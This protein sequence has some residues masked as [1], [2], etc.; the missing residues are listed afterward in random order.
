VKIAGTIAGGPEVTLTA[1]E[2]ERVSFACARPFA[3]GEPLVLRLESRRFD[4]KAIGS[5]RREDGAFD[6]RARLVNLR[7]DDR[8]WLE[9]QRTSG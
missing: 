6:V 5:K 1:I 7:R 9:E 3:P 8:A 2:A 4:A